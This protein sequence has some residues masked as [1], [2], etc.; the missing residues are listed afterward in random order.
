MWVEK[1]VKGRVYERW[2]EHHGSDEEEDVEEAEWG[3]YEGR[4]RRTPVITWEQKVKA[5]QWGYYAEKI[6][7]FVL[8]ICA[9][10]W[11]ISFSRQVWD[12]TEDGRVFAMVWSV[13]LWGMAD[14]CCGDEVRRE[15]A[16]FVVRVDGVLRDDRVWRVLSFGG[17]FMVMVIFI[18]VFLRPGVAMRK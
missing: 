6:W 17:R 4:G 2:E 15:V 12:A 14:E 5:L 8:G 13:K 16:R 9:I 10:F 1:V 11:S 18:R 3:V 7:P